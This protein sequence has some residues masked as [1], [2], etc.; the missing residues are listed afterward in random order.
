MNVTIIS[1]F[2]VNDHRVE[3][4]QNGL[5]REGH[6]VSVLLPDFRHTQKCGRT[7][8]LRGAEL[9][10]AR[11]Y[12]HNFSPG[13]I[14]SHI[15]FSED[16]MARAKVLHPDV[17]WVL[18]PPNSLVKAAA[19]YKEQRPELKLVLDV[20]DLWPEAMPVAGFSHTPPGWLWRNLRDRYLDRADVVVTE[21]GVYWK[22]L[23]KS[24]DKR[25]LY[26]L[27]T[28][29]SQKLRRLT[30]R[31]PT[32]RIALCL[33]GKLDEH[34]DF[35][36]IGKF[37]RECGYPVDLHVIGEGEGKNQLQQTA[38]SAGANVIFY[39]EVYSVEKKQNIFDSCHCGLNLLKAELS[40][41]RALKS[42]DYLKASLP[43]V[44]NVRGAMWDFVEKYPVGLN[45][46][47][48]T[49]I[50]GAKLLA[51]QGRREQIQAL[52]DTYFAEKVFAIKLRDIIQA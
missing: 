29:R 46:G 2:D 44:N 25:K 20:M 51:L 17:L 5:S 26:T 43:V 27:Y 45:Y 22:T 48:G 42:A 9:L 23:E 37:V 11:P 18:V 14:R 13:R 52:Y 3:L 40:P 38:E 8:G 28:S 19:L 16:A 10:P 21:S 34:I 32:D 24:C 33:L 7:N 41:E 50:T 35:P 30:V 47:D 36:T 12:Y 1:S 39:G 4:L 31:P 15:R 6:R 49:S